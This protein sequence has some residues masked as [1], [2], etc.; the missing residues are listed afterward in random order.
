MPIEYPTRNLLNIYI[1]NRG[2]FISAINLEIV[3]YAMQRIAK[4]LCKAPHW[5]I[6]ERYWMTTMQ[7]NITLYITLEEWTREILKELMR[8]QRS[9][10]HSTRSNWD[11]IPAQVDMVKLHFIE[12]AR[13]NIA[14]L[15]DVNRV[16]SA[17]ENL[18]LLDSLL[19]DSKY[20]FP[21]AERV[22]VGVCRPNQTERKSNGDSEL[23]VS[24]YPPCASYAVFDLDH[25]L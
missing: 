7:Q 17:P 23:L 14:A 21:G 1:P 9:T 15:D 25:I 10:L 22:D 5:Q 19:E 13:D 11:K 18:K 6:L 2:L 20:L 8:K 3:R 12:S 16:Q 4:A 24:T